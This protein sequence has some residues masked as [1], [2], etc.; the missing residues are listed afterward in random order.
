MTERVC[1]RCYCPDFTGMEV[2]RNVYGGVLFH[3]CNEC[4]LAE[5]RIF[6]LSDRL[7]KLSVAYAGAWND[8]QAAIRRGET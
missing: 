2:D 7:T 1:Q 5:P 4:H 6:R 3:V 8:R